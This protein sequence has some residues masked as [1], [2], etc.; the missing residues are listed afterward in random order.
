MLVGLDA[1]EVWSN[2]D[3][4][5]TSVAFD[6]EANRLLMGGHGANRQAGWPALAS[7]IERRAGFF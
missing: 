4:G 3:E 2:E 7:W 6:A 1:R 5:G